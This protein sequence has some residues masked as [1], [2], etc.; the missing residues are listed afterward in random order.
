MQGKVAIVT[1]AAFGI[2]RA[3]AMQLGAAGATVV[4][5]DL[6]S[7]SRWGER[8]ASEVQE[9]AAAAGV[10]CSAMFVGCDVSEGA[11]VKNLVTATLKAFGQID[12]IYSNAGIGGGGGW[13]HEVDDEDFAKVVAVNLGGCFHCAK[14][15]L[16]ALVK[17]QGALINTAS[18]FGM[19]GAH[20]ATSCEFAHT[21]GGPTTRCHVVCLLCC[22]YGVDNGVR[23][24]L[25]QG[26]RHQSDAP[27]GSR[28]WASGCPGQRHLPRLR[29]QPYGLVGPR[30]RPGSRGARGAG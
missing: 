18:T 10:T 21:Y 9:E 1:G 4:V 26:W 24:L 20:F 23:R 2:G 3:I 6:P 17:T 7:E 11:Q 13:A 15:G 28:L 27:T 16:P 25:E 5:S 30:H 8:C 22:V 12:L 29:P 19:A 14:Y